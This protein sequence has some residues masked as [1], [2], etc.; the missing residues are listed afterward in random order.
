MKDVY[1]YTINIISVQSKWSLDTKSK[2]LP[3]TI[4][5]NSETKNR[6][7]DNLPRITIRYIFKQK[8]LT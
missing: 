7:K 1:N 6:I 5:K 4:V 2:N 8:I 3:S